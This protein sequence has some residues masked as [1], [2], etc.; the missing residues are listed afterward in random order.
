MFAPEGDAH[1]GAEPSRLI[2]K[3]SLQSFQAEQTGTVFRLIHGQRHEVV[4]LVVDLAEEPLGGLIEP[5]ETPHGLLLEALDLAAGR[6]E[7]RLDGGK[8]PVQI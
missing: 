1:L 6:G 3:A 4:V 7:L 8:I 5:V 2:P